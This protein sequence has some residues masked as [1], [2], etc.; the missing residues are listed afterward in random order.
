MIRVLAFAVGVSSLAVARGDITKS[1]YTG[2]SGLHDLAKTSGKYMGTAA[3]S[4]ISDSY[5][6]KTLENVNDFGMITPG[7]AMKWDSTEPTQGTFSYTTADKIVAIA[8]ASNAQVRCHTLLWHQQIPTWVQALEKE[9]LLS[10][11]ENHITK[12]MTYFG[13]TCYAWDVANEVMGDDANYRSSFWYTKTGTDYISTAFKTANS[14]KKSLGL[15]AKLYY[16]DYN[17][18]T[19][20]AK[21]T[22]VLKMVQGLLDEGITVDG[23]GFQSHSK[24]TDTTTAADLVKNLERFTDIG[25]EVAYT[26]LD[27]SSSST[28]PSAA[29]QKQQKTVYTNVISA[30][31]QV[32]DCVGVTIWGYS[33][34]YTW[35]TDQAPLP[36]YQPNGKNSALVRKS[37]YDGIVEGWGTGS[38]TT[39]TSTTGSAVGNEASSSSTETG[40]VT[41]A[42]ASSAS[43]EQGDNSTTKTSSQAGTSTS[44]STGTTSSTTDTS[45]S[46]GTTT[47][48]STGTTTGSSTGTG[49]GATPSCSRRRRL[50]GKH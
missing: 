12:V 38:S 46:S 48:S 49:T 8:N 36:W 40:S 18:D 10:A 42:S 37:L 50:G 30:C 19:V 9:E 32:K 28:S 6:L 47:S 21:S 24:Y 3:D 44:S 27:V 20:N 33:D 41:G 23:V 22:A 4:D 35:L 7:N 31:Q 15:K 26:E 16:N 13:D 14:V 45:S 39:T 11:L 1:T 5:C 17:T 25:L 34:A 29:E 2:T 43:E